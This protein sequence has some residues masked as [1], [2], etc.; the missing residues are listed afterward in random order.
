MRGLAS[1]RVRASMWSYEAQPALGLGMDA[2]ACFP[3]RPP[4]FKILLSIWFWLGS[5]ASTP[6]LCAANTRRP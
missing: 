3:A 1:V 5:R 4:N 2:T 6:S